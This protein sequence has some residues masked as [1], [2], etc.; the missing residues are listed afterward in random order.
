MA[1]SVN[2]LSYQVTEQDGA[3]SVSINSWQV[4]IWET[5]YDHDQNT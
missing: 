3:L 1:V 4:C 2:E 5:V